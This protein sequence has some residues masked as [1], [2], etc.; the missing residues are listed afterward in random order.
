GL[1]HRDVFLSLTDNDMDKIISFF[2][3]PY[4]RKLILR[5]GDIDF[6]SALAGRLSRIPIWA[7]HFIDSSRNVISGLFM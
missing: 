5:Y 7:K 3:K 2:N 6:H 4:W 1:K